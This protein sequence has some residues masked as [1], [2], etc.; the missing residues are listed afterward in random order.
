MGITPAQYGA[1]M[2]LMAAGQALQIAQ[3]KFQGDQPAA[4]AAIKAY[5]DAIAAVDAKEGQAMRNE[6][7]LVNVVEQQAVTDAT[8]AFTNAKLNLNALPGPPI[9]T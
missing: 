2:A 9:L 5:Q 6:L 4:A 3:T 1:L 7:Y 8:V